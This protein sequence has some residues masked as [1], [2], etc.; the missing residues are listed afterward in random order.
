MTRVVDPSVNF[1][2]PIFNAPQVLDVCTT[3]TTPT[4]ISW[5]AGVMWMPY[6]MDSDVDFARGLQQ[7]RFLSDRLEIDFRKT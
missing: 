5:S 2:A 3:Q 7:K 6:D 1:N 4:E